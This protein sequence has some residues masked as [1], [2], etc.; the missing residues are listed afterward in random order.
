MDNAFQQKNKED[1]DKVV[2]LGVLLEFTDDFLIP[3]MGEMMDEKIEKGLQAFE[4]R[5]EAKMDGKINTA[6]G[7]LN[8][9]LKEFITEKQAD[10]VSEIFERLDRKYQKEKQ[11]KEK[12]LELFKKHNIGSS[13]DLAYLEG[14]V[15]G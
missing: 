15:A 2:T 6:T 9:D 7:K 1:L 8:H 10:T 4:V 12:V 11:F 14:L 13:E 3:K 5:F